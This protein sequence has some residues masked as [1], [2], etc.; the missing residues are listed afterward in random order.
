MRLNELLELFAYVDVEVIEFKTWT[1]IYYDRSN[2]LKED[3]STKN[4]EV[5]HVFQNE[6]MRVMITVLEVGENEEN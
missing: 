2:T 4:Y 5:L 3:E 6:A 1:T